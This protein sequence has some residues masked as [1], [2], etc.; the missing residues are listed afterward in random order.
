MAGTKFITQPQIKQGG[1]VRRSR[2]LQSHRVT[3]LPT[4][5]AHAAVMTQAGAPAR[6]QDL[7]GFATPSSLTDDPNSPALTLR[8]PPRWDF[9]TATVPLAVLR[10]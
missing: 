7:G 3:F 8:R 2:R 10:R 9:R 1:G 6:E 4:R 5:D